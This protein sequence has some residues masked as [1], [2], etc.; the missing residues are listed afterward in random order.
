MRKLEIWVDGTKKYE[1]LAK[2]DFSHYGLMDTTLILPAGTHQVVIYAAGYDN[3]E[4]K[5]WYTVTV[6]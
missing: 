3:L 1:E 5:K 6:Q 4:E 2:H